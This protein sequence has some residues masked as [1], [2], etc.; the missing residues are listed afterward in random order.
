MFVNQLL[1]HH[2]AMAECTMSNRH[3]MLT[4]GGTQV[5]H[6]PSGASPTC[7]S[8]ICLHWFGI[9]LDS[10][11]YLHFG[12]DYNR[13]QPWW[14]PILPAAKL[15]FFFLFFYFLFSGERIKKA[16][17]A[18]RI[19][20]HNWIRKLKGSLRIF[21]TLFFWGQKPIAQWSF[22]F[23]LG[24]HSKGPGAVWIAAWLQVTGFW[25][26]AVEGRSAGAF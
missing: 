13:K 3:M 10:F 15:Y 24:I 16:G 25:D 21:L 17:K 18:C 2:N 9:P 7:I 26:P 5:A 22:S 20:A 4:I 11:P 23:L 8:S 1:A 12:W 19:F 6:M 14:D